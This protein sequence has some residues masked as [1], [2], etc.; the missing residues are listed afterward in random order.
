MINLTLESLQEYLKKGNINAEIQTETNQLFTIFKID[1][2]EYPL[3]FRIYEG[4][5]L[6]QMVC[7]FPYTLKKEA[8]PDT[9]RLL[10]LLNK[11]I[12]IPGFCLDE[13]GSVIF[14]RV[15][16]PCFE[17]TLDETLLNAYMNAI[18]MMCQT[19]S[20]VV[21]SVAGGNVSFDQVMKKI[22]ESGSL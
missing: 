17:K 11:E 20:Q 6:L 9:A 13:A 2:G 18:Q 14:Y 3:F 19:F 5:D 15:V 21:G 1:K 16:V 12:D 7:F 4:G 22:K 10:H 8:I